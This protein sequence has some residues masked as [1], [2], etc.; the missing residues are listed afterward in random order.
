MG[1]VDRSSTQAMPA[2][3]VNVSRRRFMQAAG[4]LALGVYSGIGAAKLALADEAVPFAPNAFVRIDPQGI[5][6]VIAKHL[7][8][9][10]GI[11]TGLPTLLADELDADWDKVRVEG[12]PANT[13][14]YAN[15]LIG[16]QATGGSTGIANSFEQM[17]KAGAV[18]KAMLVRAAAERWRVPAA[19]ILVSKGVV[20]HPGSG[21][22]AGFGE[23]ARAAARLP[24]PSEVVLKKPEQF[25]LIGNPRTR[26][27]DSRGKTDGSAVY[28][29]DM[30][31]PGMLVAASAHPTRYG[32][33]VKS[34]DAAAALAIAGVV[35]VVQFPASPRGQPGVAVLARNT[36]AA[37]QGRDALKIVWDE[38]AAFRSSSADILTAYREAAGKPDA[39][40]TQEGDVAAALASAETVIEADYYVPYLAHAAMEPMNCLVRLSAD[41]CEIWNGEQW[42]TEDQKAVA[43]RLGLPIERVTIHQL[44]AGGSFGRRANPTADYLLEAVSIAQAA[45]ESG[46]DA[47]VKLVWSREDDMRGGNYRPAYLH[48][49]RLGLD[50][51]GELIAWHQRVVGQS[52]VKGIVFEA[53]LVKDGVDLIS[54]EG[55]ADPY[56]IPNLKVELHT[57]TVTENPITVQWWRS[58]GHSHTGF[59][60]ECAIDEAASASGQD[61]LVFRRKLLAKHPR[62]R[63]VLELAAEKAGWNQPLPAGAAGERRGRGIAVHQSFNT[64]VAQVVEVTVRADGTFKVDRVVCAVDCG[65]VVNPDIVRAQMEGGIGFG[66][67]TTLHGAITFKDGE[68]EQ[69]NFDSFKVLRI[70]EMPRV[71]VHIMP[72][73]E[74][75]TGVGEPSVPPVAPAVANAL[76][77]ATGRRVRSLPLDGADFKIGT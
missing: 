61:P 47:P 57:P 68:T 77:A 67:G 58:V 26:R 13:A 38:S 49:V 20:S 73:A 39:V 9:G 30:K 51:A 42:Q 2:D 14:L 12:A 62:H 50:G 34:V 74:P 76:F 7:E 25:T 45:R 15:S 8:M 27:T 4:G 63:G 52:I 43:Q 40:W 69:G 31:L 37:F 59:A 19:E 6:T 32:V 44:Y 72:S 10:Q 53:A 21:R 16:F 46:I 24:V 18:A 33:T 56:E 23:L 70:N 48:R 1:I 60:T 28:T 3:V 22:S 71:E 55:C 54:V 66:L 11:Y 17:R 65:I 36:W 41:G 5:V 35:G 29:Q 75:P 64:P